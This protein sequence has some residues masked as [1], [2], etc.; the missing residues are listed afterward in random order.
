M[1]LLLDY[2]TNFSP[3]QVA[4]FAQLDPLYREWNSKINVVSRKDIDQL[5]KHHVLHS[6]ALARLLSLKPGSRV[7]DLGCGGGFPGIPLAIAYPETQFVL[8]DSRGK[9]ITVVNEV[10]STLGLKNVKGLHTRVEEF[11][12]GRLSFDFVVTRAVAKLPQLW[13]W[14]RPMLA[15]TDQHVIPNG[16]VAWKGGSSAQL[17]AELNSLH[18]SIY[19]EVFPIREWFKDEFFWEKYLVYCQS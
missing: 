11:K 17:K 4:Q 18:R 8:V 14:S 1:E 16:L 19:R 2:F 9:K 12:A 6:L 5:Y 7:L 10:A 3:A 13:S 15:K